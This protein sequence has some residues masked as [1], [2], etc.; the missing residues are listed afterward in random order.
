[1][2]EP[3]EA[4]R[5]LLAQH[6]NLRAIMDRCL[7]LADNIDRGSEERDLLVGEAA[8][9]RVAFAAHN[10]HEESV[11]P[12]ILRDLDAFGEVRVASMLEDHAAEHASL[13][14]RLEGPTT[15]LRAAVRELREHLA[16][17]E[18]VYLCARVLH[19]D[20]IALESTS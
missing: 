6:D 8:R 3:G 5:E 12:A 16:T 1:M 18:E 10:G 4:L 14:L 9:L 11:I 20:L 7:E 2:I 19:D 17:E 13:R 15:G